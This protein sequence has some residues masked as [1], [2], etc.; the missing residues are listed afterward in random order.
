MERMYWAP[1]SIYS[2]PLVIYSSPLVI[3]SC[4]LLDEFMKG[5]FKY[6]IHMTG[7]F[8]SLFEHFATIISQELSVLFLDMFFQP[9]FCCK[10]LILR[11]THSHLFSWGSMS[12]MSQY[13]IKFFR[14]KSDNNPIIGIF[15]NNTATYS[16]VNNQK[17]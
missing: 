2:S 7:Y 8:I 3:Y 5:F 12:S 15:F 17:W 9:M 6:F 1:L 16:Q 4:C 14:L 10:C 13:S 11:Y